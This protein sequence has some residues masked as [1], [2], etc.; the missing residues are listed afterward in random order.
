MHREHS[1]S[2]QLIRKKSCTLTT[3]LVSQLLDLLLMQDSC[4]EYL[5]CWHTQFCN[6]EW[7]VICR[8]LRMKFSGQ[9]RISLELLLCCSMPK[10]SAWNSGRFLTSWQKSHLFGPKFCSLVLLLVRQSCL[11]SSVWWGFKAVRESAALISL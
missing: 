9:L 7:R 6:N 1:L 10:T 4:G 8:L 5:S 2:W 3:I 11:V